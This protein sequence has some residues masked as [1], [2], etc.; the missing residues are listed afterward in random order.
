[1]VKEDRVSM[2]VAKEVELEAEEEEQAVEDVEDQVDHV[3]L[4]HPQ[5]TP[6]LLQPQTVTAALVPVQLQHT[7]SLNNSETMASLLIVDMVPLVVPALV[8]VLQEVHLL[9]IQDME[10][11]DPQQVQTTEPHNTLAEA[12]LAE[13]GTPEKLTRKQQTRRQ[14]TK[15]LYHCFDSHVKIFLILLITMMTDPTHFHYRF[16]LQIP[17]RPL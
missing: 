6:M 15:E 7:D 16:K 1:M 4:L 5:A 14:Y 13:G 2:E 12:E 3:L 8:M 10:L 9:W 11:L 17:G